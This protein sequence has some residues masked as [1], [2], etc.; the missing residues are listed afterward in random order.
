MERALVNI[1]LC[2]IGLIDIVFH[3]LWLLPISRGLD[4][5]HKLLLFTYL[6]KKKKNGGGRKKKEEKIWCSRLHRQALCICKSNYG[7][8]SHVFE[9]GE[10]EGYCAI[11]LLLSNAR[12]H[13]LFFFFFFFFHNYLCQFTL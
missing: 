9:G 10:K 11:L 3:L 5:H 8:L 13:A 4:S 7:D 6:V 12:K 1:V 2:I